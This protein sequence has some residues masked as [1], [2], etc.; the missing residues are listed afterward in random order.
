[1]RERD[2]GR[3]LGEIEGGVTCV[4][5]RE[6]LIFVCLL[7]CSQVIIIWKHFS[8]S[9]TYMCSPETDW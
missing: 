3:E 9:H 7:E 8:L 4:Y 2:G 5:E 6:K 1:M